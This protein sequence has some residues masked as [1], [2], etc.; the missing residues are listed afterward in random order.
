MLHQN[1]PPMPSFAERQARTTA[2]ETE[3]EDL[4]SDG[5][6]E[7]LDPC[8][9]KACGDPCFACQNGPCLD[10]AMACDGNGMCGGTAACE[11]RTGSEAC[12]DN[13]YC[14]FEMQQACGTAQPEGQCRMRPE[15][16]PEEDEPICGCDGETYA[17]A[18]IAATQ[19]VNVANQGALFQI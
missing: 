13:A 15:R 10:L 6:A 18:C 17:N 11:S 1:Q 7:V 4:S 16:C 14:F 9:G 19:G 5:G 8:A 12:A 2:G 3:E